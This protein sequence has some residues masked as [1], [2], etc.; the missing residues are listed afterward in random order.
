VNTSFPTRPNGKKTKRTHSDLVRG[1]NGS[2]ESATA[3]N[4][5]ARK[6]LA[7]SLALCRRS[8]FVLAAEFFFTIP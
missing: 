7:R 2:H 8:D 1:A 3:L 6:A 5:Q 4:S